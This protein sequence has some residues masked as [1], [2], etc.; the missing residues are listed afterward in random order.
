MRNSEMQRKIEKIDPDNSFLQYITTRIEDENYRGIQCSQHN[1]I[2]YEYIKNLIK[3]IFDVAETYPFNIHV[4]DDNGERQEGAELYYQI[5]EEIKN[6]TGKGTI[7]SIKKNTFPDLSRGGLLNRY[8]REGNLIDGTFGRTNVSSVCLSNLA[9]QFIKANT[10]FEKRRI[11]TDFIDKLT[12]TI[13]IELVQLL[14]D[15]DFGQIDI[16]EFMYILS[17]D[18]AGI[19]LKEKVIYLKDYRLLSESQRNELHKLVKEYCN[20]DRIRRINPRADKIDLRD[21]NNWKNEAQQI[22]GLLAETAYFRVV[23][24]KL[25][26]NNEQYGLFLNVNPKRSQASKKEYF[27]YHN[28]PKTNNYELH[29]II[30]F[31]QARTQADAKLIDDK[32]N[33]IYLSEKKHLEFTS[34]QNKNIKLSYNNPNLSFLETNNCDKIITIDTNTDDALLSREKIDEI[35]KYNKTLLEVFY[36][37]V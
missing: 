14:T 12:R 4:G 9:L 37:V 24:N 27:K 25:C 31:H 36:K 23:N 15:Y 13:S 17:D 29:H 8:D 11:Y 20:P 3:I 26:L 18:R 28:V 34:T 19:G 30:P 10:E 16:L 35:L 32:R 22:F 21:Y 5:V 2:T 7:N 6:S 33:L 1:R